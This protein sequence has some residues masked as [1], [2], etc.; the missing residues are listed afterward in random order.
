MGRFWALWLVSVLL[1]ILGVIVM[2]ISVVGTATLVVNAG[3]APVIAQLPPPPPVF[4]TLEPF[5]MPT[6]PTFDRASFTAA[7]E[8]VA[9]VT[10]F[11]G[12]LLGIFYGLVIY[13]IG[14]FIVLMLAI[15]ENTRRRAADYPQSDSTLRAELAAFQRRVERRPRDMFDDDDNFAPR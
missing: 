14:Q 7:A 4:P 5:V 8:H 13:A 1:R 12:L 2:L 6:F 9:V 11:I 10:V 3:A 15:E